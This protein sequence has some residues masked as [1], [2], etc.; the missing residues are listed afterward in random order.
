MFK[1]VVHYFLEIIA[2]GRRGASNVILS[3]KS[4]SLLPGGGAAARGSRFRN[5]E[6][7]RL[8]HHRGVGELGLGD[9]CARRGSRNGG[10]R[11]HFIHFWL[12]GRGRLGEPLNITYS[13]VLFGWLT[14]KRWAQ[15]FGRSS[16]WDGFG[17]R[18]WLGGG[19]CR[20]RA[21]GGRHSR[22]SRGVIG[23]DI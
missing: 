14:G 15:C 16:R 22:Y 12:W 17:L 6:G 13:I 23:S 11:S 5:L 2:T 19:H 4:G 8:A 3:R 9:F 21:G 10:G 1:S 7:V 20:F 18:G